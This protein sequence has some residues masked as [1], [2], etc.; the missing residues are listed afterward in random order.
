MKAANNGQL[1]RNRLKYLAQKRKSWRI[2]GDG[3][4]IGLNE[5]ENHQRKYREKYNENGVSAAYHQA[6][7]MKIMKKIK[8]Q[9]KPWRENQ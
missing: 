2:G 3:V 9:R 8:Y 7:K 6:A 1:W 4:T 5:N